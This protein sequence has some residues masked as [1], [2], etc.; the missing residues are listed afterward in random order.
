MLQDD[1]EYEAP[2]S[3]APSAPF[4]IFTD[5][6]A[7]NQAAPFAIYDENAH[8]AQPPATST[9][10]AMVGSLVDAS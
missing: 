7:T 1:L 6:P 4:T 10:T 5:T 3:V 9:A 2:V 8:S